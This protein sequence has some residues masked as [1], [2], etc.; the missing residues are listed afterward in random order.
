MLEEL[1]HALARGARIYAEVVGF[2]FCSDGLH[3]TSPNAQTMKGAMIEALEVAQLTPA[4]IDYISL[5]GTGTING[6]KAEAEATRT[7]FTEPVPAS[8]LKSY[9]GH[10][11]GACGALESMVSILMMHEGWFHP[12]LNLRELDPDCAGLDLITGEG[13]CIDAECVMNNNYAFG[14]INTSLIFRKWKN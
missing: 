12:N 9:T 4:D 3:I 14:G 8:S 11:L 6:D 2:G 1:E 10:T 7:V 5:H 13:R